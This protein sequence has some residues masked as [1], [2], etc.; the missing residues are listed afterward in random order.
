M[1]LH[2]KSSKYLNVCIAIIILVLLIAGRY[3]WNGAVVDDSGS[4]SFPD[5]STLN[6][7]LSG[8]A[9]VNLKF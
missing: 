3:L 6:Q 7:S 1:K 2:L 9:T 5:E 8:K 4:S